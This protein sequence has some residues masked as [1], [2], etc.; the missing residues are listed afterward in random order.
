MAI[1]L[2]G[3]DADDT[4]W[5]NEPYFR[6]THKRFNELLG[7]YADQ[8]TL[9]RRLVE[10]M[11]RNMKTYGYGAKT[12]TLSMIETASEVAGKACTLSSAKYWRRGGS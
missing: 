3:L 12:A 7:S 11:E 1:E 5:H 4:L 10:T 2:V 6:L 9:D 8:A